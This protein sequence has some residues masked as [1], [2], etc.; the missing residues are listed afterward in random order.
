[1]C[2]R[3]DFLTRVWGEYL[4]AHNVTED[5]VDPDDFVRWA[6]GQALAHRKPLYDGMAKNW[7]LSVSASDIAAATTPDAFNAL[8]AQALEKHSA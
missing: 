2:Y 7:G 4:T 3:A 8:I 5:Q 1:M 6:Y